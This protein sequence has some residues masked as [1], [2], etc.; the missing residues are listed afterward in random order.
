MSVAAYKDLVY[1]VEE[2]VAT[3]TLNRP[4][5]LNALRELSFEELEDAIR[6]AD[7]EPATGVIVIAGS[8]DSRAFC[9]GG[10]LQMATAMRSAE[11]IRDHYFN[12]MARLSRRVLDAGKP[13]IAAVGGACIGGGAELVL[14]CD[15]VLVAE[16]AFFSYNGTEIGGASWWGAPQ[17]LP[18]MI[19]FRRTE[20]ILYSSRRVGGAEAAEIG[21]ATRAVPRAE[22]DAS[23]RETCEMLLNR[24]AEGLRQT[25]ASLRATKEIVLATMSAAAESSVAGHPS[26]VAAFEA[27]L[28]GERIDWRAQRSAGD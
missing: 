16:D 15:F 10:D 1:V 11:A 2:G 8:P 25:K 5:K 19:G 7:R 14:F 28:G 13:V 27:F 9:A 12:R 17:L 24:S 3:I 21:I 22:L 23:V 6:R 4:E 26:V 20:E 18:L